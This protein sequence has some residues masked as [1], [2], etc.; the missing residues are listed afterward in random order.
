MPRFY[1]LGL[2]KT[3]SAIPLSTV[4]EWLHQSADATHAFIEDLT[5]TGAL[6]AKIVLREGPDQGAVLRFFSNQS[7]GP[8]AKSESQ[9]YVQLQEQ[10]LRT[11]TMLEF[12]KI[13]DRR[14]T[15][16]K[17]YVEAARK[18]LKAKDEEAPVGEVMDTAQEWAGGYPDEDLMMDS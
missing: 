16:T 18:K 4:A 15:L 9:Y 5:S 12:V 7:S 6:N 3:Y 17:E 2:Q 10:T 1:V 13:A 8:L 14:L 11:N